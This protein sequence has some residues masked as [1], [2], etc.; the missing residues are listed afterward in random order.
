MLAAALLAVLV[1]AA[2]RLQLSSPRGLLEQGTHIVAH[3]VWQVQA[4]S[5]NLQV[6]SMKCPLWYDTGW[7]HQQQSAAVTC[8]GW[9]KASTVIIVLLS[10]SIHMCYSSQKLLDDA[11][12]VIHAFLQVGS[13][14]AR[15]LSEALVLQA[16]CSLAVYV[17]CHCLRTSISN[18]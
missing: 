3:K 1:V 12:L 17:D 18:N 6:I 13:T 15:A 5:T 9:P 11:F 2:S 16:H 8:T 7:L 4:L 10:E 14:P